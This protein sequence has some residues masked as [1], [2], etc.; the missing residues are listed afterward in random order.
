MLV[1]QLFRRLTSCLVIT[2]LFIMIFT[3]YV[4]TTLYRLMSTTRSI[5]LKIQLSENRSSVD[6]LSLGI[7]L[8]KFYITGNITEHVAF[9]FAYAKELL[10]LIHKGNGPFVG[11]TI[12]FQQNRIWCNTLSWIRSWFGDGTQWSMDRWR[13]IEIFV[14][15]W[16][17]LQHHR[18][19]GLG[20]CGRIIICRFLPILSSIRP[21]L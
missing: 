13:K 19:S 5:N 21:V 12:D 1:S 11:Q 4:L 2:H 15:T 18:W 6:Y 20:D 9:R 17:F 7:S 8:N 3:K 16:K 10:E 14:R